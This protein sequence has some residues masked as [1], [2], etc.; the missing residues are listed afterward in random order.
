MAWT[1]IPSFP[2]WEKASASFRPRLDQKVWLKEIDTWIRRYNLSGRPIDSLVHLR[3]ALEEW[4]EDP[5]VR[6]N[7]D[8]KAH[9]VRREL[10]DV[11]RKKWKEVTKLDKGYKEVVCV[12]YETKIDPKKGDPD[13]AT[14]LDARWTQMQAAILAAYRT[15]DT[16]RKTSAITDEEDK[17]RLKIFM[18]PE[19]YFRGKSGAYDMAKHFFDFLD[20]IPKYT[21]FTNVAD[22][23]FVLG[24]FVCSW[25]GEEEVADTSWSAGFGLF[26]TKKKTGRATGTLENY[27]LVQKGGFNGRDGIHDIQVGKE[28]PSHVDFEKTGTDS[29][30]Y[31]KEREA[32]VLGSMRLAEKPPGGRKDPRS[33]NPNPLTAAGEAPQ[34]EATAFGGIFTMDQ[35]IFGLE[36]CRDHLLGRLAHAK[37]KAG[38]KVQLIPSWGARIKTG[39]GETGN[40]TN[41][42]LPNAVVF[43]VDG[44][45]GDSAVRDSSLSLVPDVF[46]REVPQNTT[47]FPDKGKIRIYRSVNLP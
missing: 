21:G 18:A 42:C 22:W 15:Y 11:V 12:A 46:E 24:T 6:S 7:Q 19:F 27:A 1:D 9:E 25:A 14:D 8:R 45:R 39:T 32:K 17:E 35:I 28:F 41:Y 30:W 3:K 38:V 37:D 29:E 47:Y 33:A 40:T 36:V 16:Y 13:D 10:R 26:G 4:K 20:K 2:E 34:D 23:L 5:S 43:N 31:T 44:S